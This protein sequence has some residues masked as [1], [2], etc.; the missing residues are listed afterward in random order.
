MFN[1]EN[2][3]NLEAKL[4]SLAIKI[5]EIRKTGV[6]QNKLPENIWTEAIA[7]SKLSSANKVSLSIG[8]SRSNLYKRIKEQ[9]LIKRSI[10]HK[11][12]K[13]KSAFL[14]I[15]PLIDNTKS[16][17][18]AESFNNFKMR[19]QIIPD[20]NASGS[21]LYVDLIRPDGAIMKVHGNSAQMNLV[22]LMGQFIRGGL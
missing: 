11:N 13:S 9:K 6:A 8:I 2:S 21:Y 22:D 15:T 3:S 12:K 7:L 4:T 19:Q 14:E 5:K 16:K 10:S 17:P 1:L 18:L 20:L